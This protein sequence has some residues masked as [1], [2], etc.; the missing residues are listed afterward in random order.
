MLHFSLGI[1]RD[2]KSVLQPWQL[3]P[4]IIA[5]WVNRHQ[6]DVVEYRGVKTRFGFS[7]GTP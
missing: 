3:L 7:G 5:G 2:M 1:R 4:F 6:Q